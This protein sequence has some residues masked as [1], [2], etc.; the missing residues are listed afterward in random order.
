MKPVRV[1]GKIFEVKQPA[2]RL[3]WVTIWDPNILSFFSLAM[4]GKNI[5]QIRQICQIL[6]ACVSENLSY[7][8]E[9]MQFSWKVFRGH[10]SH[11]K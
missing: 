3:R 9:L 6:V 10:A 1:N 2:L 5:R 4:A 7:E 8:H 11:R